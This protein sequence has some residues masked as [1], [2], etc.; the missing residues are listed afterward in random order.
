MDNLIKRVSE[1]TGV[2]YDKCQEIIDTTIDEMGWPEIG[3]YN[4][5]FRRGQMYDDAGGF[6]MRAIGRLFGA[7]HKYDELT[8]YKKSMKTMIN[9]GNRNEKLN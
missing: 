2:S 7:R 5:E 3:E 8:N 9:F 6:I 4:K 1:R